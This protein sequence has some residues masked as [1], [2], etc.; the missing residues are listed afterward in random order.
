MDHN[1]SIAAISSVIQLALAP[2]FLLAGI[3][4][5]LTVLTLRLG[6]AIDRGRLLDRQIPSAES[7][8]QERLLREASTVWR[9]THLINW[10]MR[11]AVM[12]ALLVCL[13]I[14]L[15]FVGDFAAFNLGGVVAYL[16]IGTMAMLV[17]A[18]TSLLMEVSISTKTLRQSLEHRITLGETD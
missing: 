14:A 1:A 17:L 13:L 10:A 18:L 16:F 11:F 12:A 9:R 15:L 8:V 7:T 4:A 6:R 5:L 3:G 2:V